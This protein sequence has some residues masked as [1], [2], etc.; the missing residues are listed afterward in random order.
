MSAGYYYSPLA[1]CPKCNATVP[2]GLLGDMIAHARSSGVVVR[3]GCR[4]CGVGLKIDP[5]CRR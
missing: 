1:V 4:S 3:F 5:A 2:P